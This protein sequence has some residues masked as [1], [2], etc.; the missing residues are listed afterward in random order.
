MEDSK[1]PKKEL[2][3]DLNPS[4]KRGGGDN[5]KPLLFTIVIVLILG[6]GT[7]Y[8][9]SNFSGAAKG[10]GKVTS[11]SAAG[12]DIKKGF[13][14]GVTNTSEFPDVAEGVLKEGGFEGE[15]E[16]HLIRPGGDSQ[17]AYLFSSVVDFSKFVDK[18]IKVWGKSQTPQK[19]G[20]L[21]D[22]G[23]IEVQ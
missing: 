23:K 15:G 4:K 6:I 7:G 3:H 21:L 9:A 10:P 19:V 2:I 12:E 17:T 13:T 22:V 5:L 18:K 20:W 8:I 11:G 1:L 14:A 16:Y